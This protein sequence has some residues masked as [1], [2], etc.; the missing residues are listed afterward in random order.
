MECPICYESLDASPVRSTLCGHVFHT[1]CLSMWLMTR[2]TCPMCREPV[3]VGAHPTCITI[4]APQCPTCSRTCSIKR[5]CI[6]E[7]YDSRSLQFMTCG[8]LNHPIIRWLNKR[9]AGTWFTV[10]YC[11]E[12]QAWERTD[13]YH[14]PMHGRILGT[15]G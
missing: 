1:T 6:W 2:H 12:K 10:R 11:V 4:T 13:P 7:F 14:V 5:V 8:D 9:N 3:H 15:F